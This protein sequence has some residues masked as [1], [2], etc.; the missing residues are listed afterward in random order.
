M[1]KRKSIDGIY[2]Y[3][4]T[5]PELSLCELQREF[6]LSD[7]QMAKLGVAAG[8]LIIPSNSAK[9]GGSHAAVKP[10][11]GSLK[12]EKD[13]DKAKLEAILGKRGSPL[14]IFQD[15]FYWFFAND[16]LVYRATY[17]WAS[18]GE[19]PEIHAYF[20]DIPVAMEK[21]DFFTVMFGEARRG[22]LIRALGNTADVNPM[23]K[24][25]DKGLT[26]G[27]VCFARFEIEIYGRGKEPAFAILS[28][29][30]IGEFADYFKKKGLSFTPGKLSA[31][32]ATLKIE[33]E[34]R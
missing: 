17:G 7:A 2:R 13:D 26:R 11:D 31:P 4:L 16:T 34:Y 6:G 22:D 27:L 25:N 12:K 1:T 28:R 24:G 15:R 32:L 33:K 9:E 30:G 18:D 20:G 3:I 29:C 14:P 5:H 19:E 10:I 21:E 8:D 23:L